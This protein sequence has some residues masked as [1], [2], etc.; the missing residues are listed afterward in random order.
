MIMRCSRCREA[1]SA[2]LDGED[3]GVPVASVEGHLVGCAAC[4]SWATAAG[5]L[6]RALPEVPVDGI[7]LTPSVLGGMLEG[8]AKRRSPLVTTGEWRIVLALVAI[9]QLVLAVPGTLLADGHASA[10]VGHELTAWDIGLALGFL[11]VAWRPSR[12]WGTL[13]V[14][15][16]LV[17]GLVT[18]A[19]VDLVSGHALLGRESVHLLEV[20]GLGCLW[21]LARRVPRPSVVLRL[22]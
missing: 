18:T 16:L 21:V 13:P 10:H 17:A 7:V 20:A 22:A 12:A 2:R 19:V 15:A 3:P 8:A 11:V 9:A 1:V 4:R 5:S 14:I 6:T